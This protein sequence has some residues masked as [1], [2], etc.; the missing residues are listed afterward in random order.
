MESFYA[1]FE[2]I[3]LLKEWKSRYELEFLLIHLEMHSLR[4]HGLLKTPRQVCYSDAQGQ[5]DCTHFRCLQYIYVY[6]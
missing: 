1:D 4:I 5:V 3:W 6:F 2:V